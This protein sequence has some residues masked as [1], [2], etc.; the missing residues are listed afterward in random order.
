VVICGE[1]FVSRPPDVNKKQAGQPE[2]VP[3]DQE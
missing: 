3:Q 1:R 2:G